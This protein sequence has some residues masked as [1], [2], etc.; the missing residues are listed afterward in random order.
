MLVAWL[1]LKA[2]PCVARS[3]GNAGHLKQLL[4]RHAPDIKRLLGWRHPHGGATAIYVACELGHTDAVKLLLDAGAPVDLAR[5]DGDT[6][7]FKAC[8]DGKIDIVRA[9]RPD[10]RQLHDPA[11]DRLPSRPG[12]P[13]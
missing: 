6:P 11:V 12:G 1:K 13:R 2:V 9:G 7:L 5:E 8:R 10:R 3:H 4:T